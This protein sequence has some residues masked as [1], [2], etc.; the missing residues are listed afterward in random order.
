MT[1]RSRLGFVLVLIAFFSLPLLG[2]EN[3]WSI[4]GPD[5]GSVARFTFDP[6]DPSIVYAAAANGIFRSSDGGQHW[7]AAAEL[8]GTS[9]ADLEVAKSD[10]RKVYASTSFGLYKS[11]DRGLTWNVVH[12]FG[13]YA[14][15]VSNTNADIVYSDSTGGP[16]RSSDGGVSFGSIGLGLPPSAAAVSV[17]VTDP[18]NPDIVYASYQTNVG[19]Y[20]SID[21]GG[22]WAAANSGLDQTLFY[23]LIIDPSN[24]STLYAG[25][26]PGIF[27]TTDGGTTWTAM[28]N[29]LPQSPYCYSLSISAGAPST[30]IAGTNQGIYKTTN[31]GTGWT[32]PLASTSDSV[33]ATSI[34]PM[35]A[36]NI[37]SSV[38]FLTFRSSNGGANFSATSGLAAS[39]TNAIAADPRNDSIVYAAGPTGISK[40]T[41]RGESWS[42]LTKTQTSYL[43]VDSQNSQTVYAVTLGVFRRS[44]DGGATWQDYADGLPPSTGSTAIAADPRDGGTLYTINGN[45][46]YKKSGSNPW[47]SSS[48]GLPSGTLSFL[49]IDPNNS[50]TLYAGGRAGLFKST[51]GGSSWGGASGGINGVNPNGLAID[52]FDSSH[53]LTW[54]SSSA[55]ESTDGGANWS[56]FA[57]APNR[58]S[59][60]LAFDPTGPGRIYNSSYDAFDRSVDGGKSW[61]PMQLGLGRTHGTLL[62]IASSGNTLYTGGSGG[63]VWAIHFARGRSAGH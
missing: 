40:S 34:D 54:T 4:K 15:A 63:G 53:L 61:V 33:I 7:V 3:R 27:K 47:A 41:D 29:G 51:N 26:S 38:S 43:A 23:S 45:Q 17:L 8:L 25:G 10:P 16:F 39:Y 2:G 18:Q 31:G 44:V 9:V 24:G 12:P 58:Q 36:A 62:A 13:S 55:Y 37:L 28:T 14:V 60:L 32:G 19:V 11:A 59:I 48:T 49:S 50:A 20:K 52:P 22:H 42:L 56:S 1:L 6:A 5:G 57:I 35:N 30:V 46:V 21:G